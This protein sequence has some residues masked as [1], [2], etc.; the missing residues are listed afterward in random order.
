MTLA[1]GLSIEG[2]DAVLNRLNFAHMLLYPLILLGIDE[3]V[4]SDRGL[5]F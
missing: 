3:L 1:R 2:V 5:V 4:N